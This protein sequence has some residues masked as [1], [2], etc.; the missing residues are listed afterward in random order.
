[1]YDYPQYK[2]RLEKALEQ[3]RA[4]CLGQDRRL[5]ALVLG[6]AGLPPERLAE[7]AAD[8][9]TF[10]LARAGEW[11]DEALRDS[12]RWLRAAALF[13]WTCLPEDR[14]LYGLVRLASLS[15][16]TREALDFQ[17][18]PAH[19]A[20]DLAEVPPM[21]KLTLEAAIWL[22]TEPPVQSLEALEGLLT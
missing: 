1:M 19:Y 5:A 12:W 2:E 9:L 4:R 15:R 21:L 14:T 3:I 6:G 17:G 7:Q 16:L 11:T 13:L 10:H 18:F 20:R 8:V 22:L